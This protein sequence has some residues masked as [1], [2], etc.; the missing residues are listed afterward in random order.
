METK[1]PEDLN[2]GRLIKADIYSRPNMINGRYESCHLGFDDLT[3]V[4]DSDT[5]FLEAVKMK[6][7]LADKMLA[8]AEAQGKDTSD[9]NVMIKLGEEI[10]AAGKPFHRWESVMTAIFVS[11]QLMVCYGIVVGIWGLVFG[12]SFWI[13]GFYGVIGGF[14]ISLLFAA[15][16]VVSQRTRGS[17]RKMVDSIGMV[18]VNIPIIVGIMGLIAWAIRLM[19]FN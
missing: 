15:P 8:E 16:A 9:S 13:F 2:K 10:N 4:K 3:K 11:L 17:I 6:A 7:D 19:F 18:C 5:F 14:L 1:K 12:Q